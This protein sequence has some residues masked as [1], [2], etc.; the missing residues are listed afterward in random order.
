MIAVT[1]L[2][3]YYDGVRA[4]E[5]V[6]FE[7][8]S[9][10]ALAVVGPSGSGK[11]TLLRLIAGLE[12]PDSGEVHLDGC[13]VSRPG[14]ALAPHRRGVGLV[15][16][17]PALW[18][19]MTVAQNILFGLR[20]LPHA[21]ARTRL[22]ALLAQTGLKGLERRY[23]HQISGGQARRVA[24]A[25]ALAPRPRFLLLDEP[26]TNLDARLKEEMLELILAAARDAA[27]T[28]L[29][30][31]HQMEEATRVARRVLRLEAGR[32]FGVDEL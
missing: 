10:A 30:V 4:L 27:A 5:D 25:R 3:R 23:P 22:E 14:W 9:G 16:Q 29:Y 18:P 17:S 6:S 12:L 1:S 32:V 31:T 13:V 8:A 21:E 15:F 26:L 20:G 28:L 24:L 11:T 19:H 2:S 7:I